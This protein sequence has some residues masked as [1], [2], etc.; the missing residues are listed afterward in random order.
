MDQ[1]RKPAEM[2]AKSDKTLVQ[3]SFGRRAV[4]YNT[5]FY[6]TLSK[7]L[8]ASLSDPGWKSKKGVLLVSGA[9]F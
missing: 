7:Q 2:S 6:L 3:A 9:L 5:Y 8:A 1:C 4:I